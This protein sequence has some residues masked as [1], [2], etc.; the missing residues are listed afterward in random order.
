MP[1]EAVLWKCTLIRF[2]LSGR[3][4][5]I[6]EL[7][8]GV[9]DITARPLVALWGIGKK[10]EFIPNPQEVEQARALVNYRDVLIREDSGTMMLRRSQQAIDLGGIAK[11]YAADEVRRILFMH[12]ISDALINLGGTVITMGRPREVGIQHPW[13][14]TG[15]P[16]GKIRVKDRAVVTSGFYEK[17]F[18]HDEVRYHHILDPRTG[19]PSDSGLAGVTLIGNCAAELDALATAVFILGPERGAELAG[20][21][22]AES[23]FIL[24]NG[25]VLTSPGLKGEFT[26][27]PSSGG[28]KIEA[29]T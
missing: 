3:P 9:F 16:L 5:R 4:A 12:G 11:G 21:C 27:L 19:Y 8:D 1:L 20:Q 2:L 29:K 25:D 18:I 26:L 13:K 14:P 24:K 23:I 28:E 7:A 6:S 10:G 17:Y 22:G 15:M